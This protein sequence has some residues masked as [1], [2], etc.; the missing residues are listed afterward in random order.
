MTVGHEADTGGVQPDLINEK[1]AD[2]KVDSS[3]IEKH[4]AQIR[5]LALDM[6]QRCREL[7]EELQQFHDYLRSQQREKM[8]E[9]KVFTNRLK[10][11]MKVIDKVSTLS[12]GALAMLSN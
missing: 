9:S 12:A 8:V 11:E 7:L 2:L 6:Q 5:S 4:G 3:G 1:M 10:S